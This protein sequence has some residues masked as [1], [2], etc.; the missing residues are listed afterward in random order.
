MTE[1][2]SRLARRLGRDAAAGAIVFAV[3]LSVFL[4]SRIH[5]VADSHYSMLLSQSLVSR[6]SFALDAYALPRH[7]PVWHGYYFKNGP[8]YQLEVAGGRL[9]YHLPPGSSVLSAPFVAAFNLLGVSPA[10]AD[11][12][13]DP[14]GEV[15]IEAGLAALLMAALAVVF[16]YTARLRL[17]LG[18]SVAAALGAAF[19]TQVYSTASRALWSDTWG[20][21]LLGVV[22]FL[23]LRDEAKGRGLSPVW[24]ASL[25]AWTYFVRPTFAVHIAMVSVY[26]FIYR[27]RLF[28]AYALTGAAWLALFVCYSWFHFGEASAELLRREPAGVR[29]LLGGARGKLSEPRARPAG[30]RPRPALRGLP[31]RALPCDAPAPAAR[32][33]LTGDCRGA[34]SGDL[35]FQPLVGR[36][37]LRAA[38]FDGA[39]PLVLPA[40]RLRSAR[41]ARL[42]GGAPSRRCAP[43][44]R[45]ARRSCS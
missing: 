40:R 29:L 3:T 25:L 42:A 4:F 24:L 21:L 15:I 30:L 41:D 19:G 37:Q 36:A 27:R 1:G 12:S 7:E 11:G 44:S 45:A 16:F 35:Q 8:I 5:Q 28:L 31:A 26:I 43:N 32:V 17:P 22:V 39:R 6:A 38:L 9:Y 34:S 13:Y 33:A 10:A 20:I 23:L 14:R 18:W 2:R